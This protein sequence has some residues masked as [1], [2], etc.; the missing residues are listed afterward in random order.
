MSALTAQIE[1]DQK[2]LRES[3]REGFIYGA[4]AVLLAGVAGF[5][6]TAALMGA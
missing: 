1:R 2:A 5:C 3:W 4:L 6:V